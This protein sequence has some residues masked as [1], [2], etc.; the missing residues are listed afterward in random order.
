[1]TSVVR[2]IKN[3][4]HKKLTIAIYILT[5]F[6]RAQMLL[7]PS[8]RLQKHW[9]QSGVE[10]PENVGWFSYFYAIKVG[11]EE[12]RIA[13]KTPWE[14]KCLVRALTARRLLHR[15]KIVTTLYLGVGKDENDAMV[16]HSWL[17]CGKAYVTGGDGA[18]YATVAKFCM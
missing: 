5:A 18:K 16:A 12:N 11:N 15:K 1:M 8:K 17:R 9:G 6:Y 14:S 10:S 13:D 7:V 3:N 4:D 2:F